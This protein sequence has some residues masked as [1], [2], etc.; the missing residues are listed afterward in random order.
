MEH[1]EAKVEGRADE[2]ASDDGV[3]VLIER[4]RPIDL[5]PAIV[6]AHGLTER[7]RHGTEAILQGMVAK[8][9]TRT[10]GISEYTV[11]DHLKSVF[12]RVDVGTGSELIYAL[13]VRHYLPPTRRG[14]TPRTIWL[15]PCTRDRRT[16]MVGPLAYNL[17]YRWWAPWNAVGVRPELRQVLEDGWITPQSHPHAIDLGCGS[18]ANVVFLAEQGFDATGVDFSRVA[19]EKARARAAKAGVSAT[20]VEGDLTAESI[21]GVEG[22]FDFLIDFGT[23]DDLGRQGRR[24]MAH[25]VVRLS[26]PGTRFLFWCFYDPYAG[27]P[28]ISFSGPSKM[29]PAIE[30]GEEDEL[31][32]EYFRFE[33]RLDTPPHTGC[34]LL[35]RR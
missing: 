25:T 27:L 11:Q 33:G 10:L 29:A 24:A 6:A 23:L 15:L 26:R 34:F 8:Q 7:E 9:I 32:G 20:F 21:P 1:R 12:A 16:L 35:T 19:L 5:A 4:S 28:L 14:A 31:F 30:P 22:T 2:R 18:G 13:Y 3:S 17:M